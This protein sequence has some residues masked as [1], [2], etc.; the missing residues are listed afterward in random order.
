MITRRTFLRGIGGVAVALPALEIMDS[1][2]ASRAAADVPGARPCRFV[3]MQAGVSTGA[4]STDD[5]LLVPSATG[6]GYE[7]RPALQS[8]EDLGVAADVSLVSG[9]KIPWDTGGGIPPGGRSVFYHYNTI[10]PQVAGTATGTERGGRPRGPTCDQ[11]VADAIAG[12]T[13]HRLLTYRVQPASYVGRNEIGGDSGCLSWR[14]NS[15]GSLD[16][17]EPTVSPRLAFE[18]LFT[19]FAPADPAEAERAR[20]LLGRRKSIL[21]LVHGNTERLIAK[22]GTGDRRR[23]ERHFDEIRALETR[24]DAIPPVVGSCMLPAAPG[25][26]PAIGEAII[27]YEGA[28]QPYSTSQGY[29]NEDLRADVMT[30]LVAMA[31]ACDLS[32]VASILLTEW[33]CYMNMFQLAGYE[34]DMHELTH[35][36]NQPGVTAAVAWHVKQLARLTLKLRD[37]QDVDGSSLLDH[38]AIVLLFEGG[39]GYDPEGDSA[40]SSHS[41]EN[42]VALI[43][44]RAGGLRAGQHFI[45][46]DMHPANVVISAMNAV[47]VDGGLGDLDGNVSQLF[48]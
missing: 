31:F 12:E 13:P 34:S 46:R 2:R 37:R 44:G 17:I 3:V 21:D 25:A 29:S 4:D 16:R 41:T 1:P 47:G 33:K 6:A 35:N 7:I 30:D 48:G 39:H 10:G 40:V 23:M 11:L 15:D 42:M 20:R 32:R 14:S 45:A 27:E 19:G 9:L 22:L 5:D 18:S 8:L 36:P 26:D 43:A 28:G 38:T 24:L